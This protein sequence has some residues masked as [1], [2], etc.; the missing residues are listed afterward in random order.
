MPGIGLTPFLFVSPQLGLDD[1][2]EAHEEGIV[3]I[4]NNRPDGEKEGQPTS[5]EIEK[6]ATELGV[7]YRHIPV[8]AGKMTTEKIEAFRSALKELPQ[9]I[10]AFC[11][12]GTRSTTLWALAE[13]PQSDAD[14]IISLAR[15]AGYNLSNLRPTLV[16]SNLTHS[17]AKG[18]SEHTDAPLDLGHPTTR[19]VVI[20]GGGAGG[21]AVASSLLA[22][23]PSLAITLI[24]PR[25]E[26]YYQPGWTMVG[27]GVF[28][29]NLTIRDEIRLIP[30]GVRWIR[31]S[32]AGFE[33][34]N[35][36]VILEDGEKVLYKT[37]I[38][39]AG[40]KLD[41]KAIPG[42]SETLGRNGVTSNYEPGL[43]TYTWEL[44]QRLKKGVALFT[45]P[46]MPIKCAGAPQKAMYLSCDYW[47]RSGCLNHINVEFNT[48]GNVLFGIPEY[49]PALDAYIDKYGIELGLGQNLVAIDGPGKT[50]TFEMVFDD[51]TSITEDRH[52]DMIHVCPPQTAPDFVRSSP[53]S[54]EAGWVE[55]DPDTL[56]HVR[57]DNVYALGDVCSAPNAKTAAAVRTQA[58]IVA[59]NILNAIHHSPERALY[60][61]YG[62][63]PL[64]VEKG[65]IVLAEFGYGGKI[66]PTL[67]FIDGTKPSR[68]AWL[69]KEKMLPWVYWNLMLKGREWLV[70]YE[71][72]ET[73]R[74]A[75]PVAL[76][77]KR[78]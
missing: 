26:H 60:S 47:R 7:A 37:L 48:A 63:C 70:K 39:A 28:D 52:F 17:A 36:A 61:G 77:D 23:E 50:A 76:L 21:I 8:V 4:I 22:R 75:R 54:N 34:Q 68:I 65:K 74:T 57:Y 6:R 13:A 19:D 64:T 67:P 11:A 38:V 53:L 51:G 66:M 55:V 1:V 27:G 32:A 40:L 2:D 10:L 78:K 49:V 59:T 25:S 62:S 56:Q 3:A 9:P 42:L 45:Q 69:L 12:T 20:V 16:E 58:P 29:N 41:W 30:A 46:P 71:T 43:A 18:R 33:P 31:A 14:A 72:S 44:V 24:E 5:L 73:H 15:E 35:N